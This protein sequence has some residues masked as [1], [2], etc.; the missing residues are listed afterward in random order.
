MVLHRARW[1]GGSD[2]LHLV[3]TFYIPQFSTSC[4]SARLHV[5]EHPFIGLLPV[6]VS[7]QHTDDRVTVTQVTHSG[8]FAHSLSHSLWKIRLLTQSLTPDRNFQSIFEAPLH[9]TSPKC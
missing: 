2:I 9:K 8:R 4:L 7:P 5:L 6:W 3:E 1:A